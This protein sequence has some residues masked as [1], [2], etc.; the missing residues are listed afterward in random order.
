MKNQQQ[1]VV[2]SQQCSNNAGKKFLFHTHIHFIQIRTS[3]KILH[4]QLNTWNYFDHKYRG[5]LYI[6]CKE[7]ILSI[8]YPHTQHFS[9]N[10]SKQFYHK[11]KE[12]LGL[13][14]G[15]FFFFLFFFC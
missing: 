6:S 12:I 5:T 11:F 2:I 4:Q 7:R 8:K 1:P 9:F 13:Q 15:F 3:S 10:N 14:Q